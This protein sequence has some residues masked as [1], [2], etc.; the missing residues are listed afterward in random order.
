MTVNGCGYRQDWGGAMDLYIY[1]YT[2]VAVVVYV[3]P[4]DFIHECLMLLGPCSHVISV[5]RGMNNLS[6]WDPRF[7]SVGYKCTESV[8]GPLYLG[9]LIS[10]HV[11]LFGWVEFK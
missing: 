2:L 7:K 11:C 9:L 1:I 10:I 8:I 6:D 4:L 5:I 3:C